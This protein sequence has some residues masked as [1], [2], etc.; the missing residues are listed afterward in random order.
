MSKVCPA[1]L[2]YLKDKEKK[3]QENNKRKNTDPSKEVMD[4]TTEVSMLV[5][6]NVLPHRGHLEA[7]YRIHSY[8]K[9]KTNARLVLDPTYPDLDYDSFLNGDA[10]ERIPANMPT[11]HG[12]L[13]EIRCYITTDHTGD[14]LPI[15]S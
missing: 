9:M 4:I 15:R 8:L 11:L 13:V 1:Y 14:K 5:S 10:I 6:H 2:M 3:V 12:K 7:V